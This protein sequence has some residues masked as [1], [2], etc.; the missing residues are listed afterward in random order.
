MSPKLPQIAVVLLV[1]ALPSMA[2]AQ[3]VFSN[4][5]ESNTNG[6][7]PGGSLPA[8]TRTSLPTDSGGI[9]SANQSMWLGRLGSGIPKSGA[10]DEIVTLNVSGLNPGRLYSVA[11]DLFI[12][13]SWDGSAGG[14]GPDSWRFAVDGTRL[15][16]TT[17][18]NGNAGQEYGAYSPQRYSDTTYTSLTGP[19]YGKFTGADASFTTG[20]C[21]NYGLHYGIYKFSRGAG[22]PQLTFRPVGTDVVL[23]F[24]RFGATTDSGDEYWALDNVQVARLVPEPNSLVLIGIAISAAWHAGRRSQSRRGRPGHVARLAG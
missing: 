13:A 20:S 11:F 14:F 23:E 10:I 2:T 22:N 19:D 15:V 8:L 16:N 24:A 21:C 7:T 3:V 5:F 6:F 18:T 17:F 1:L 12:G 9:S 4:D